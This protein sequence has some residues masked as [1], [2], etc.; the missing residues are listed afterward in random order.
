MLQLPV[1][2]WFCKPRPRLKESWQ[3]NTQLWL[4]DTCITT[5]A[6]GVTL[7]AENK[8]PKLIIE[9]MLK[10]PIHCIS[11]HL[12]HQSKLPIH[13]ISNQC[14]LYVKLVFVL[15]QDQSLALAKPKFQLQIS[16]TFLPQNQIGNFVFKIKTFLIRNCECNDIFKCEIS[17]YLD[18]Y[19]SILSKCAAK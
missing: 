7:V 11:L 17:L 1:T 4:V 13:A 10:G 3:Q 6:C 19:K 8:S 9:L 12:G 15:V 18:Y 2:V 16:N 14:W 5:N